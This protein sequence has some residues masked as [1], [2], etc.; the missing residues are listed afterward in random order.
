MAKA[1]QVGGVRKHQQCALQSVL[2]GYVD[3]GDLEGVL[4]MVGYHHVDRHQAAVNT[5]QH[6]SGIASGR[7]GCIHWRERH[8]WRRRKSVCGLVHCLSADRQWADQ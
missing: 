6:T 7:S 3:L 5:K 1:G 4:C 8:R 2:H